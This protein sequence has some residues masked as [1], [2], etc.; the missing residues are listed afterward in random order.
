MSKKIL[1]GAIASAL[2]LT[3]CSASGDPDQDKTIKVA[4]SPG[5]YSELFKEGIDPI[6][7]EQGYTLEYS[8]FSDLQQ[9]DTSVAEGANDLIVD[10][11]SAYMKVF[12][13][14]TGSDLAAITEIPTVPSALFSKQHASRDEVA[15]GQTVGVPQDAS[16]K[17]RAINI[18]VDAGWVTIKPEADRALLSETD[19]QDNKYNL[20]IRP[21]DSAQ[22]PRTLDDLDWAVI[23]GSM[24]YASK[25]NQ[26]WSHFQENL[27][28][29]L[30]L[31]AVT[32]QDEVDSEWAQAV[33]DAYRSP[34]F[35]EFMEAENTNNYWFVPEYS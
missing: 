6:L 12:N 15:E 13:D 21:M 4:T 35:R 9:A 22:L 34:E 30:I 20:E 23:P 2:L 14:N 10:Q 17:S 32:R 29:E 25:V 5:P 28:P 3:G 7:S 11:H 26:E 19:I 27:R 31:V 24:S 1:A 16:N 8:N 18:L 33:A